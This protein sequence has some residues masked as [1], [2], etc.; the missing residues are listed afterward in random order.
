MNEQAP[1]IQVKH[2]SDITIIELLDNEILD[3]Q[4]ISS[5]ADALFSVV[6]ENPGVK[7]LLSFSRVKH[8]SSSALGTLIRLNKRVEE[9]NGVLKLCSIQ[10]SLYEIFLITKLNKL[11][12]IYDS[13]DAALKAF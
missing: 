3:E 5:I 8:L 9:T 10:K 6:T 1:K 13:E 11:F 4:T 7:M 2:D 12:D